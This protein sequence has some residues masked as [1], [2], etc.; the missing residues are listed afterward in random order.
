ME[1]IITVTDNV[2]N[3]MHV[4]DWL[5]PNQVLLY[6]PYSSNF[7]CQYLVT[8]WL[9]LL[10]QT[11]YKSKIVF[12]KVNVVWKCI[13]IHDLYWGLSLNL[14]MIIIIWTEIRTYVAILKLLLLFKIVVCHNVYLWCET[15]VDMM[16]RQVLTS[17][18][19]SV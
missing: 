4:L 13:Y 18:C 11:F 19:M 7:S 2:M 10:P 3:F 12:H 15:F 16:E 17:S 8:L 9:G 6:I 14:P 1:V 5:H